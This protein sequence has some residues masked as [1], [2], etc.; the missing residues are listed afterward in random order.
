MSFLLV[1]LLLGAGAAVASSVG[2]QTVDL[3]QQVESL[4]ARGRAAEACELLEQHLTFALGDAKLHELLARAFEKLGREDEAAVQ[5]ERALALSGPGAGVGQR[6]SRAL[7]RLDPLSARRQALFEKIVRSLSE[8]AERLEA[9]GSPERALALAERL[10]PLA[11][12]RERDELQALCARIRAATTEL[13]LDR[14]SAAERPEGGWPL[15]ELQ[16]EHYRLAANLEPD[17]AA[18]VGATMDDIHAY[19][20]RTYLDGE[21]DRAGGRKATLRIHPDQRS[22][23]AA[24]GGAGAPAG[25]WSPGEWAV[26]A[27]DTRADTGTLDWMLEVLFH[28]ASHQ[29]MT[30][31]AKGGDTPAWL[32]EGTAS[33]FEGARIMADRAV[34]WPDVAPR[35]LSSLTT[36]LAGS[37]PAGVARIPSLAEVIGYSQGGSYGPEYYPFGWGLVYFLQQYEDPR[38]LA[39]VLRPLYARYRER[40]AQRGGDPLEL[41]AQVFLDGGGPLAHESLEDFERDWRGW[42]LEQVQPLFAGPRRRELRRERVDRYLAAAERAGRE[43][44]PP[45]EARE[46]YLRALGDIEVI[47]GEIDPADEPDDE[48]LLLQAGVLERLGRGPSA[49]PLYET[50]LDRADQGLLALDAQRYA[51][52]DARLEALDRRNAALRSALGRARPLVVSARELLADYERAEEPRLLRA[53]AFASLTGAVLQDEPGLL[54]AAR[55]L[56]EQARERGLLRGNIR[57]LS[58]PKATWVTIFNADE[59][60]FEVSGEGAERRVVIESVR[61][62]GRLCTALPVAGEYELRARLLRA[63]RIARSSFHGVVCAGTASGDWLIVGIDGQGRLGLKRAV[64]GSGGDVTDVGLDFRRLD[65]GPAAEEPL[66]LLVRVL[67]EGRVRVTLGERTSEEFVLPLALP[68]SGHVGLYVKDGRCVLEGAVVETFP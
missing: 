57:A 64:L 19:Y 9:S 1:A 25:W 26:H 23:L 67:P 16:S 32:N 18:L 34:L 45:V 59:P 29:F 50:V 21:E 2:S 65:P 63:G 53:Y 3:A 15:L 10:T 44:A 6:L 52:I 68:A 56:R 55:R 39:F 66:E 12:G 61:P 28:E 35:R 46:L 41:F 40:S 49:A 13:D 20:V 14:A 36:M 42:I 62:A 58:G 54:A 27:Y 51:S 47:R 4:L 33:F 8:S 37:A 11:A 17:V 22:L 31:V 48:L 38:T 60:A 30:L 43:R 7:A 24:W 5:L